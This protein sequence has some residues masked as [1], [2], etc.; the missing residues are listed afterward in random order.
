MNSLREFAQ[1][2]TYSNEN[3]NS[4]QQPFFAQDSRPPPE[5]TKNLVEV[6]TLL[7]KLPLPRYLVDF[8]RH[9][10]S[11]R[12]E[13]YFGIWTLM[14]LKNIVERYNIFKDHS[15]NSVIDFARMYIS[16][17]HIVVAALD[18]S[19]D[20]IFFR[21]DGGSNGFDRSSHWEFIKSYKP[22]YNDKVCFSEWVRLISGKTSWFDGLDG[23]I[24][25]LGYKV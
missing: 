11:A 6:N 24:V 15:Q 23:Y 25:N 7:T 19:D 16:G 17:G 5:I 10:G 12:V 2:G 9:I 8:Y 13:Y 3:Y 1:L 18:P 21:N 20:K 4:A 22:L 14:S